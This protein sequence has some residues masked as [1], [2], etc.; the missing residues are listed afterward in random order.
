MF[1]KFKRIGVV[2]SMLFAAG[3]F[4]VPM[5]VTAQDYEMPGEAEGADFS[6][7]E[8][9]AF[10]R[11]QAQVMEIEQEFSAQFAEAGDPAEQQAIMEEANEKMLDVIEQEGLSIEVFNQIATQAQTDSEL[12][13]QLNEAMQRHMMQ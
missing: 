3:L 1:K 6:Q 5:Q 8:I 4:I 10:A 9:S 2:F 11:A 12:Q 13:Q 7:E